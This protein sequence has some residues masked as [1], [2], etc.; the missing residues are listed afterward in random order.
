MSGA[1]GM[2]HAPCSPTQSRQ[3]LGHEALLCGHGTSH[4]CV[5]MTMVPDKN[6]S[7]KEPWFQGSSSCQKVRWGSSD[8]KGSSWGWGSSLHGGRVTGRK[9]RNQGWSETFQGQPSVAYFCHVSPTSWRFHCLPQEQ[10]QMRARHS[11][12]EPVRGISDSK[13]ALPRQRPRPG[14]PA[15]FW[16]WTS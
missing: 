11:Q 10:H 7:R 1:L 12:P 8:C 2:L 14:L 16:Q 9:G 5:M 13:Q 15:T 3:W 4:L 6:S